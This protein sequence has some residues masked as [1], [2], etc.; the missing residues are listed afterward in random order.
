MSMLFCLLLSKKLY[1]KTRQCIFLETLMTNSKKSREL[2]HLIWAINYDT[3]VGSSKR[4]K[5]RGF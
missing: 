3:E 1:E 2:N 4:G 5:N